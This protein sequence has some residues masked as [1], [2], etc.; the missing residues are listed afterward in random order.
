M[1]NGNKKFLRH[2]SCTHIYTYQDLPVHW[3]LNLKLCILLV[4][5]NNYNVVTL[6]LAVKEKKITRVKK[7]K[8]VE[9]LLPHITKIKVIKKLLLA[10]SG[11]CVLLKKLHTVLTKK[12]NGKIGQWF[13]HTF[14]D[15]E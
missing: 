11:M 3:I 7:K 4:L 8:S 13:T 5:G 2:Q 15:L 9:N 14:V 12:W 6:F 10:V 1:S